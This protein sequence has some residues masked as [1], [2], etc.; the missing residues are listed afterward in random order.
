[1]GGVCVIT[2]PARLR[3]I[4]GRDPHYGVP[5]LVALPNGLQRFI[6]NDVLKRRVH[7]VLGHPSPAYD[8]THLYW[9]VREIAGL[10]PQPHTVEVLHNR[11]Y[12]PPGKFTREWLRHPSVALEQ[13]RF[14]VREYFFDR[15]LIWKKAA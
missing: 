2:T 8:V 14:N 4:F 11:Q 1:A 15:I 13:L 9:N 6:V 5:G 7:G 10:F 3:H 12:R